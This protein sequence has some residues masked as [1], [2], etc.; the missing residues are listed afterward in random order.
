[1]DLHETGNIAIRDWNGRLHVGH[2]WVKG[3]H[4][5]CRVTDPGHEEREQFAPGGR[6]VDGA[7]LID[8]RRVSAS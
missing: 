6:R 7:I 2:A 4:H 1:M 3:D 8:R 5:G